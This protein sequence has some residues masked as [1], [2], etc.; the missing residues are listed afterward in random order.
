MDSTIQSRI[1][2]VMKDISNFPYDNT[3]TLES[4]HFDALDLVHLVLDL[5]DEFKIDIPD[6]VALKF[7]TMGDIDW[8]VNKHM[9]VKGK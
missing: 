7:K 6:D 1:Q 9:D 2:R 8:Y 5:E 3:T 4:F